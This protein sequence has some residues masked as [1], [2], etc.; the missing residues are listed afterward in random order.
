MGLNLKK[1][2]GVILSQPKVIVYKSR[3]KKV[4]EPYPNTKNC[5]TGAKKSKKRP[6]SRAKFKT[7]SKGYNFKT[8]VDS[9]MSKLLL[10]HYAYT[11][12]AE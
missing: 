9:R 10:Q 3:S 1:T 2:G 5:P 8:K 11:K 6:K 12:I 7:S 4:L